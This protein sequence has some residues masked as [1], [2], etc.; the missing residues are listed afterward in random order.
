MIQEDPTDLNMSKDWIKHIIKIK[1]KP[2]VSI[3]AGL[4]MIHCSLHYLDVVF[5]D[6]LYY[7]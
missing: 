2:S 5:Y 7:L 4:P 6:G 1:I 3:A